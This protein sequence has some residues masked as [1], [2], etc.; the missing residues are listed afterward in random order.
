LSARNDIDLLFLDLDLFKIESLHFINNLDKKPNII[1]LSSNDLSAIKDFG[2]SIVDY[3]L[4]PVTYSRFRAA[5]DK[6]IRYYPRKKDSYD[7]DNA[8]FLKYESSLV[9]VKLKEIIYIE[10]HE[11]HINVTT[12]DK[13]FEIHFTLNDFESQLPSDLFIRVH[14]TLMVNKRMIQTIR[15]D[16]LDLI[17]GDTL[18]SFPIGNTLRDLLLNDI[19][20]TVK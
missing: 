14:K 3:L 15:E 12:K 5:I 13:K 6:A 19:K 20:M 1:I 18:I 16:S 2:I 10:A 9:K 11:H 7:S 8:I 17:I 4:K